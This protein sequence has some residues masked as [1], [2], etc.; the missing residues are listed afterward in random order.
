MEKCNGG[1]VK[2]GKKTPCI[3]RG[4]GTFNLTNDIVCDEFYWEDGL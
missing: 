1:S 2:F 3:I 4:K